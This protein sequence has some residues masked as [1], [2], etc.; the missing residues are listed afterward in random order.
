MIFATYIIEY[1]LGL[2]FLKSKKKQMK[3]VLIMYFK[4][5]MNKIFNV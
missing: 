5:N 1:F 3:W 4:L 2:I